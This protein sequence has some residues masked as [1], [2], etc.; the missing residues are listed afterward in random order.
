MGKRGFGNTLLSERGE[1]PGPSETPRPV[2]RRRLYLASA[3][4]FAEID[5][6]ALDR[7]R[8][9]LES[10]GVEVWE[11]FAEC[12]GLRP[13]EAGRR[14]LSGIRESDGVFAVVNGAALDEG[15]IVETG[16]A[17]ALD[18][19][20]FLFRD[21]K[22]M[23]ADTAAYPLN[24]MICA[25]LPDDWRSYWYADVGELGDA[26]KALARWIGGKHA[27]VGASQ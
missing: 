26:D 9:E 22:R 18:K 23:C 14:R 21:D 7:L 19:P 20:V 11:P 5:R 4:G 3:L 1:T 6:Y 8:A 24:L 10:L 12:A 15:V 17:Y 25:G 16:Y 2:R 13:R 27:R